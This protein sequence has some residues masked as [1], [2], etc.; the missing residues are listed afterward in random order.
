MC[1]L[2]VHT[3]LTRTLAISGLDHTIK[4]LKQ[5]LEKVTGCPAVSQKLSFKGPLK[6]D[7]DTLRSRKFTSKCKV[8]YDVPTASFLCVRL[9]CVRNYR[10]FI[11]NL[12]V[13]TD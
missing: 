4:E 11:G 2:R 12:A 7:T 1:R 13:R 6:N 9:L 8:R 3:P 10:L 5:E